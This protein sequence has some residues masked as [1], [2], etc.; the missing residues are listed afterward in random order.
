MYIL[1]TQKVSRA[2]IC[3]RLRRPG[4]DSASLAGRYDKY[5]KSI[6]WNGFLGS[7]NVYKFG[8]SSYISVKPRDKVHKGRPMTQREFCYFM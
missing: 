6:P 8:L 3:K 2:R 1:Y 7:S 4:I 5:D